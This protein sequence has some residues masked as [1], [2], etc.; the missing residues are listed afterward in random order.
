MT[1]ELRFCAE[2]LPSKTLSSSIGEQ[3]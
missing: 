1:D 2:S 3:S